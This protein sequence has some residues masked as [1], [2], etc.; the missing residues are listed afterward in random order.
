[1]V[2]VAKKMIRKGE[3]ITNNY[4]IHHNNLVRGIL[5]GCLV[6]LMGLRGTP[7]EKH[8]HV[9]QMAKPC[10]CQHYLTDPCFFQTTEQR[11]S[12]LLQSYKFECRCEACRYDFPLLA[13]INSKLPSKLGKQLESLLSQYQRHFKAGEINEARLVCSKYLSKLEHA[14]IKYPHRNYEIGA[15]ALNSCWWAMIADAQNNA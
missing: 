6:N 12:S 4:G 8:C 7:V 2:V 10:L 15:I 13:A 3:E 9:L 5:V 14:D 11:K 1:M